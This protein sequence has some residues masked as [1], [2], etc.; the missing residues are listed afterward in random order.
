LLFY[1]LFG[2]AATR[3]LW[4]DLLFLGKAPQLRCGKLAGRN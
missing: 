4:N 3:S 2:K 1:Q